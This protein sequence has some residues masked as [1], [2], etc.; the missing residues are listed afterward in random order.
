MKSFEELEEVVHSINEM[1]DIFR[2]IVVLGCH[3]EQIQGYTELK[4]LTFGILVKDV[5]R[6]DEKPDLLEACKGALAALSQNKTFLADIEAA[7]LFL[8][9]AIIQTEGKEEKGE[10][11]R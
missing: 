2:S 7:K 10:N 5:H 9:S 4:D 11:N 8:T 1:E 6:N 3:Q